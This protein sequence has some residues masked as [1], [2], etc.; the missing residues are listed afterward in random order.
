MRRASDRLRCLSTILFERTTYAR[1]KHEHRENPAAMCGR[2]SGQRLVGPRNRRATPGCTIESQVV[3]GVLW[4]QETE[5]GFEEGHSRIRGARGSG[6][7]RN[8]WGQGV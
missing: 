1:V 2:D 7:V 8:G 3:A 6:G 5:T 4:R